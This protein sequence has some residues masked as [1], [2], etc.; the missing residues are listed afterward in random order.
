MLQKKAACL[1]GT[2]VLCACHYRQ[3]ISVMLGGSLVIMW[4]ARGSLSM[5]RLARHAAAASRTSLSG[6]ESIG[7]H[8]ELDSS[9][10]HR[11]TDVIR[12]LTQEA[13]QSVSSQPRGGGGGSG[14]TRPD[15]K[16]QRR[17]IVSFTAWS[18]AIEL[19]WCFDWRS[20]ARHWKSRKVCS[21]MNWTW[22]LSPE[23]CG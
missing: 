12:L 17:R 6:V 4:W 8:Q 21:S 5:I 7:S 19:C 15:Y 14:I 1:T 10:R 22:M 18:D 9:Q 23:Y 20:L 11:T 3:P 2:L 16:P 13:P